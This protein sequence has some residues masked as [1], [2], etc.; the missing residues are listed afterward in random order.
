MQQVGIS[1]DAAIMQRCVTQ[2]VRLVD[3]HE[4]PL[5][6]RQVSIQ[7]RRHAIGFGNIAFDF[8]GLANG[9]EQS[10]PKSPFGGADPGHAQELVHRYFDIFNMATLPFYW[11]VFEAQEGMP[12]TRR[13]MRAAQWIRQ[14][15]A[16][17]KGHPLA[18]HTLAP[19]WLLD[20][21]L[22]DVEST[23]RSRIRRDVSD[24]YGIVDVWDA[25]NEVVIMPVF[26]KE[27]NA[28]TRLCQK[29]G[30]VEMV[31]L[32]FEC[33]RQANPNVTLL[34]NDFNM[35]PAYEA[36]IEECLEAGIRIDALGLQSHMHQGY[37]GEDKTCEVLD[38]FGRFGLPLHMT[39]TTLVS[40]DLMPS[41]IVDLND[42]QVESWPSTPEGEGRQ[43]EDIERHYRT[44][45]AN[46][47]VEA[48]TYWGFTD[49]GSW[50]G[51]PCGLVRSDGTAK[52]S[53]EVL[54][55]LIKDEWWLHSSVVCTDEFGC[56]EITALPGEYAIRCGTEW[57][58][59]HLSQSTKDLL[60]LKV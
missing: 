16:T 44:L 7:Q 8:I 17:P 9:E 11:A 50:L 4:L 18:W 35:S 47:Q 23:L 55:R 54:R 28:I 6:Y 52:P 5:P 60:E 10:D 14:H 32:A 31:R 24:F 45:M 43:A 19:Q 2:T 12:D 53:Y 13:L 37:W 41:H 29:L 22:D 42:Y 58:T 38:R 26:E 15:G 56:F 34:L 33:A 46:A 25:I 3:A 20:K 59:C 39:E 40:G 48:I 51:A 57:V 1:T 27:D 30:R 36:L 21:D 49:T